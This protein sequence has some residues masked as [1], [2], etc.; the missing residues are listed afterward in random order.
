[1]NLNESESI[2]FDMMYQLL[3][4]KYLFNRT[5]SKAR[6][7]GSSGRDVRGV[8]GHEKSTKHRQSAQYKR[9]INRG[10]NPGS[11]GNMRNISKKLNSRIGISKG[12]GGTLKRNADGRR[13]TKT[14]GKFINSKLPFV[15][16]HILPNGD[17]VV[18]RSG[19]TRFR[20]DIKTK[21]KRLIKMVD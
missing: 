21:F 4:E 17:V 7:N 13:T 19:K 1:M 8:R 9:N 16:S 18:G 3:I 2:T 11:D 12:L 5:R 10:N 14:K 6:Y 20:R 15:V